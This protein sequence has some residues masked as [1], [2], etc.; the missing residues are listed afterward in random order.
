M[1]TTTST[2]YVPPGRTD[3]VLRFSGAVKSAIGV[4][5]SEEVFAGSDV[6]AS[7]P[8]ANVVSRFGA[9]KLPPPAAAAPPSAGAAA[10]GLD[11]AI[12]LTGVSTRAEAQAASD[13]AP[14]AV[15]E[16]LYSLVTR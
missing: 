10:A 7:S 16:D 14:V 12:V 11:G 15:A 2:R 13:P 9:A 4:A 6:S 5:D 3:A 8:C 1:R